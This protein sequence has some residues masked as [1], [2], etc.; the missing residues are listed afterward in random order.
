MGRMFRIISERGGATAEAAPAVPD[1]VPFV[2][3]GGPDGV[4]TF[5]L[6]AAQPPVPVPVVVQLPVAE[7]TVVDETPPAPEPP[8]RVLSVAFHRLPKN[9]L[10]LVPAGVATDLVTVH[11]P[12]HPVSREYRAVRDEITAQYDA[13]PRVLVFAAA[14]PESGATTVLLNLAAT[15]AADAGAKVL[16]VDANGPRPAVA[17]RLGLADGPGLAEV[18]AQTTPLAWA[19]QPTP[20]ANLHALTA[21]AGAGD[22]SRLLGTLRGWF[23]WVLVDGGVWSDGAAAAAADGVY[24]VARQTDL[25]RPEFVGLRAAV[26]AAGGTPRGYLTTRE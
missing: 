4:V 22:V 8:A 1:T 26:A 13:G 25:D 5:G 12:D 15:L 23:D 6:P 20:V 3:V 7:S 16:V 18:A 14:A 19:I 10:R 11:W 2:E 24:L 21:G 17:A 9:G